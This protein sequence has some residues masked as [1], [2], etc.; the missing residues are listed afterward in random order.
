MST[1][2]FRCSFSGDEQTRV[3]VAHLQRD[4]QLPVDHPYLREGRLVAA[5]SRA[6]IEMLQARSIDV[7]IQADLVEQSRRVRDEKLPLARARDSTGLLTGF[8]DSYLDTNSVLDRFAALHAAFPALTQW[9]DLPFATTGYDGTATALH[10]PARVKLFRIT[11]TPTSLAKPGLLFITGTHAREWAPP[12][13]AIELATQLLRNYAPGSTDPAI[14]RINQLISELD[15]FIIPVLNPDGVNYSYHDDAMWRKNRRPSASCPGVDPNRNY[16]IYWGGAGASGDPCSE[17]YRGTAAFSESEPRNVQYLVEQFA[18]ILVAVDCHSFGEAIYRPQ[19]TGGAYISHEPVGPTDNAI[20]QALETAINTAV[21]SVSPGKHYSAGSTSNH[22]GTSDEYLYF[23]HRIFAFDLET[24]LD[25]QPPISQAVVSTQEV[26]AG[27]RAL[28]AET[29]ALAARMTDPVRVVQVIDKSGSMI[30][31]GY[32]DTT[33]ANARRMVDMMSLNDTLGIV[34]FNETATTPLAPTPI[35]NPGVYATARSAVDAIAFG[36]WTSIGAGLQAAA[37]ALPSGNDAIML[38][39]D[40][41][42]NRPPLVNAVLPTLPKTT[43]V[44]SVA[45]GPA[46]DQLL[47]QSIAAA[48]SGCY[49]YSPDEMQLF[50]IY[51]FIRGELTNDAV[52][53]NDTFPLAGGQTTYLVSVDEGADQMILTLA[54]SRPLTGLTVRL[55]PP[56]NSVAAPER[57]RDL[58]GLDYHVLRVRRPDAGIWRIEIQRGATTEPVTCTVGALLRSDLRLLMPAANKPLPEP[59]AAVQVLD[60]TQPVRTFR[61]DAV[62]SQPAGSVKTLLAQFGSK[63]PRIPDHLRKAPD[64]LPDRILQAVLLRQQLVRETGIDPLRWVRV[65]GL[66]QPIEGP[67]PIALRVPL[68]SAGTPPV[69]GSYSFQLRV[70]GYSE[71]TKRSFV[72]LGLRCTV[73]GSD[74]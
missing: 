50:E 27:L 40:G 67:H 18:N 33:R 38:L 37:A 19:P 41:R 10:G 23:A 72:R 35:T 30:A 36:G 59:S 4:G 52:V 69:D 25:F 53:L 47:L 17:D 39:S 44:F 9:T 3:L 45:L 61:V 74:F 14:Q 21:A 6:Q 12:L 49:Y 32:A 8:V 46:S 68:R 5:L 7:E 43:R 73:V 66:V 58:L 48:T 22:A 63:L 42:E 34:S 54:T 24:G 11:T 56:D 70:Q 29:L 15:L 71:P 13:A 57:V 1:Q 2:L 28:G 16:S 65:P 51:N 31:Y 64:V 62:V 26:A 60:G 20:Y 55:Y